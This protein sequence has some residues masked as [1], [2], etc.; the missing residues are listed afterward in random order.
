LTKV[1]ATGATLEL[2][3]IAPAFAARDSLRSTL[4]GTLAQKFTESKIGGTGADAP[5]FS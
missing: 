5:S 2:H 1:D 4:L 3:L